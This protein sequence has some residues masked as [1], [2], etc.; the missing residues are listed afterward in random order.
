MNRLQRALLASCLGLLAVPAMAWEWNYGPATTSEDGYRRVH[1][2]PSCNPDFP[3]PGYIAIGTQDIGGPNPDVYVTYTNVLGNSAA[4]WE[5]TYDVEGLGL[6]DDGM[7]IVSVPGQGYVFLS[8]S[9]YGV[10]RPALT[11][12]DCKGKVIWSQIYPDTLANQ[13]L[14]GND[15]IRTQS[16][17][18]LQGTNPGDF[19]VAGWWF[20]STVAPGNDDAFL[21]RTNAA[22][23]LIWNIAHNNQNLNEG[24]PRPHRGPA[25]AR[26]PGCRPGGGRP[27]DH[28]RGR[29]AGPGGAGERQHRQRRRAR[30]SACSSTARPAAAEY[31]NSVTRLQNFFAGQFALV[32]VTRGANWAEDIW[33]TR[34]NSCA[35]T[36]QARFG[37]PA[38]QVTTERGNDIIEVLVAKPARRPAAWRSPA[39]TSG[40]AAC[41]SRARA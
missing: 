40:R 41:R 8:N 3:N 21:M 35:M 30:R 18:P 39:T 33:V 25:G 19:A 34:S 37:N 27:A 22:G 2:V 10:W 1:P 7:A 6:A 11:A 36:A 23:G 4:G 16:G 38:G 5:A 15:L 13:N 31:Y 26:R 32:G 12:I 28:H 20:N 17:D 29:P 9:L 14:W 24:L